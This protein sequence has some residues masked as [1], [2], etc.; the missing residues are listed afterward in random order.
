MTRDIIACLILGC[1]FVGLFLLWQ[2]Y[3]ERIQ[4]NPNAQYSKWTPPPLMKLSLWTRGDGRFSAIM[5]IALLTW[6]SFVG[7]N[8]WATV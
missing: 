5:A 8:I 1:A 7:W 3:L 4:D 2:R 6:C